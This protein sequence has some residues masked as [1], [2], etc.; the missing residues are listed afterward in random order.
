[1][2]TAQDAAEQAAE[3]IRAANHLTFPGR[4]AP[5]RPAD[6]AAIIGSLL[7]MTQRLPQLLGQLSHWLETEHQAGRAGHDQR[8]DPGLTVAVI[9]EELQAAS[10]TFRRAESAL[11][12]AHA[13]CSHLTGQDGSE[14]D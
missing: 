3:A 12:R 10:N 5:G 7:A 14:K 11:D 8:L 2:A 9:R 6:A 4:A 1:M 13:A